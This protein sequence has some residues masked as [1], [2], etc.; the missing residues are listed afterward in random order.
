M[1]FEY[2]D[3]RK[4]DRQPSGDLLK[5][6]HDSQEI[7]TEIKYRLEHLAN[8]FYTTGNERVAEELAFIAREVGNLI[9]PISGSWSK[10]MDTH[11]SNAQ[12]MNAN[13]LMGLIGMSKFD[14]DTDL[15]KERTAA[16]E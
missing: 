6:I 2:E 8:A 12:K 5:D 7:A 10:E 14:R 1:R 11:L 15:L 3:P 16:P 9:R 4:P 13:M